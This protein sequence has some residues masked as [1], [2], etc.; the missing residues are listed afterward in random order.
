MSS[1]VPAYPIFLAV[2]C[3]FQINCCAF[4]SDLKFMVTGSD[5]SVVKLWDVA[6]NKVQHTLKGHSGRGICMTMG[7]E[8]NKSH[9]LLEITKYYIS[10][11]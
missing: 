7:N 4:S 1:D 10:N 8:I 6:E 11:I 3:N 2:Y 9:C 5:D